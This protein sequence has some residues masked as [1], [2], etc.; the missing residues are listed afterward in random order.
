VAPACSVCC[1][2]G[3]QSFLKRVRWSSL[4]AHV[5]ARATKREQQ[6]EEVSPSLLTDLELHGRECTSSSDLIVEVEQL[7]PKVPAVGF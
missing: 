2:L 6:R 7:Q 3:I 4:L 1:S 5:R